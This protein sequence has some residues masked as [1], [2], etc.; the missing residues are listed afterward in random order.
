MS[1]KAGV[2]RAITIAVTMA[3]SFTPVTSP[4]EFEMREYGDKP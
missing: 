1:A 3:A 2:V 4:S